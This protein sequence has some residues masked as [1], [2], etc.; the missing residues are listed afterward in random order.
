M[1]MLWIRQR[2]ISIF[3]KNYSGT[4]T[5]SL[6]RLPTQ[7]VKDESSLVLPEVLRS[8]IML[9]YEKSNIFKLSDRTPCVSEPPQVEC[10][11][12]P[13]HQSL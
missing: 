4:F 10:I 13:M 12:L 9:F 11:Y 3:V 8:Q 6:Q 2:M 5:I 1:L 7:R